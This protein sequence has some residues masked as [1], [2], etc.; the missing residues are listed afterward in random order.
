MI[1]IPPKDAPLALSSAKQKTGEQALGSTHPAG[2][3]PDRRSVLSRRRKGRAIAS[4]ASK[5]VSFGTGECPFVSTSLHIYENQMTNPREVHAQ[6]D[7]VEAWREHC[8]RTVRRMY[9]YQP[10]YHLRVEQMFTVRG[11]AYT[12]DDLEVLGASPCRGLERRTSKVFLEHRKWFTERLVQIQW[13][14]DSE[15]VA[16]F[17]KRGSVPNVNFARLLALADRR[18]ADEIYAAEPDCYYGQ[19]WSDSSKSLESTDSIDTV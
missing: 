7:E 10:E 8:C 18:A 2:Y 19:Y 5:S 17:C 11:H 1:I 12:D 4:T 15:C 3:Q 9:K 16:Y 14:N 6:Q 13:S